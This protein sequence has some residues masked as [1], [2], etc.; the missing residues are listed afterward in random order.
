MS[1]LNPDF[2]K[3][4]QL[5]IIRNTKIE[6]EYQDKPEDFIKFTAEEYIDL[7]IRFL[8]L[9]NPDIIMERFISQSPPEKL[10]AP[11]WGLKNFEFTA[12]LEKEMR[13]RN[14]HQGKRYNFEL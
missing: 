13:S 1:K 3:L 9:L 2:L 6:I 4:H 8:E 11:I 12:K 7:T 5:Q 14:T 10:I